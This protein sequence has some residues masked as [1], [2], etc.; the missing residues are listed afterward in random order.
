MS[1]TTCKKRKPH[2]RGARNKTIKASTLLKEYFDK[3][4]IIYYQ[5]TLEE[6]ITV[7]LLPYDIQKQG[8]KL[9]IRIVVADSIN[10]CHMSFSYELNK[11][12][13]CSKELLDMNSELT[14]GRLSVEKDSNQVTYSTDFILAPESNVQD[15]YN[16]HFESCVSTLASLYKRKIIKTNE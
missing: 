13:D 2:K 10:F 4:D 15:L 5:R 11:G 6:N 1:T 8:I 16:Q 14:K 9:H 7:F 12:T 3:N